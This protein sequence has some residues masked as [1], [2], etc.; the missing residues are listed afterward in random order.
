[1]KKLEDMNPRDYGMNPREEIVAAAIKAYLLSMPEVERL[2]V[3]SEIT[4]PKVIKMHGE[5]GVPMPLQSVVEGAKLATFIG[6]AVECA[7]SLI[8]QENDTT[9]LVIE[10][11]SAINRRTI[12]ESASFEFLQFIADCYRLMRYCKE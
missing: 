7:V 12:V 8:S 3:L 10:A 6:E 9:H 4:E 1:M 11:L 5:G 2:K